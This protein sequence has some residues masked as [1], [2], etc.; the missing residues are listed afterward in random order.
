MPPMAH[1]TEADLDAVLAYFD[2]MRQ[3]KHDPDAGKI[4]APH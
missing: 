4:V 1:L 2:A 3:R